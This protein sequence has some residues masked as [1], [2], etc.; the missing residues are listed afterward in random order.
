MLSLK[1]F[2]DLRKQVLFFIDNIDKNFNLKYYFIIGMGINGF[3]FL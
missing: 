3:N 2:K 1:L